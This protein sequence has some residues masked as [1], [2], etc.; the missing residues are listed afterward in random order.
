MNRKPVT[1]TTRLLTMV[2]LTMLSLNVRGL[3]NNIKRV[4][5]QQLMHR[6]KADDVLIQES[7]LRQGDVSKIQDKKYKVIS[8]SSSSSKSKG[9]IIV[10][11]RNLPTK[12]EKT[13]SDN[14]GRLTYVCTTIYDTKLAFV[15]IYAQTIFEKNFYPS[16]MQE[17]GTMTVPP[18]KDRL[19]A[20]QGGDP[21]EPDRSPR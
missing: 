2:E 13:Y 21:D 9:V 16:V 12:I 7:H 19:Q 8:S 14:L 18:L 15:A 3:N 11:K 6:Q 4:K 5:C 17:L 20:V 10:F 1:L